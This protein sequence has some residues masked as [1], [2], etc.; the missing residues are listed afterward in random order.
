MAVRA[1]KLG[2]ADA[3]KTQ[4][5]SGLSVGDEVVIDGADRLR[6]GAKVMLPGAKPSAGAGAHRHRHGGEAAA[7]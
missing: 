7:E 5:L 3:E 4:V 1:V 6:D 2:V